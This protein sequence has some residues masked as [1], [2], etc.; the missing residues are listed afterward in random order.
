MSKLLLKTILDDHQSRYGK[1]FAIF[2]QVLVIVSIVTF[3]LDTLPDLSKQAHALLSII[4]L[5][6]VFTFSLEY[7][8][9]ILVADNKLRFIVSFYGIVDLLAILPFY[10]N[11]GIDLRVLRVVRLFKLCRYHH[12][13]HRY[14][15]ALII[16]KEELALFGLVTFALLYLSAVGIYYFEHTVQPERFQSVFDGLWWAVATLTTVGY[17]DIYPIT[18]G[19]KVLT[20]II[21]VLGLGV[22]AVPS[23]LVAS[24]LSQ[25]R[26]EEQ[27]TKV[28][29]D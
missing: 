18:A 17:G 11:T 29:T 16:V 6:I 24:A 23:G 8:C 10:F 20:F 13:T 25:A 2:I 28:T 27:A 26:S 19:G 4:E 1:P 3:S 12:A 14:Y 21:L 5:F 7:V 22:V 9:R 15:R